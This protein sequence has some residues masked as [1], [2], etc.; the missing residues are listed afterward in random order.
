MLLAPVI[1]KAQRATLLTVHPSTAHSSLRAPFQSWAVE[2]VFPLSC[3]RE[4]LV[5][6]TLRQGTHIWK[7]SNPSESCLKSPLGEMLVKWCI[8]E[9]KSTRATNPGSWSSFRRRGSQAGSGLKSTQRGGRQ[10][11]PVQ[12]RGDDEE[13]KGE[14][15]KEAV[16]KSEDSPWSLNRISQT[17][18]WCKLVRLVSIYR[19]GHGGDGWNT[20]VSDVALGRKAIGVTGV[21]PGH[22]PRCWQ[23]WLQ[24]I[25]YHFFPILIQSVSTSI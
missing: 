11:E 6:V 5:Q 24:N 21:L 12:R 4:P 22:A 17:V 15:V 8:L 25:R 14:R 18:N 20:T 1:C 13:T 7:Q 19:A 9:N 2:P 16:E 10:K 23:H 3:Y